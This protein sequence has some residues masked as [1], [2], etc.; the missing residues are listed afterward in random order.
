MAGNSSPHMYTARTRAQHTGFPCSL[1]SGWCVFSQRSWCCCLCLVKT[2]V[3]LPGPLLLAQHHWQ[4]FHIYTRHSPSTL[5]TAHIKSI[6]N[7]STRPKVLPLLFRAY[8]WSSILYHLLLQHKW[9]CLKAECL[10]VAS[11]AFIK[12]E[13]KET[14]FVDV[15]L[16]KNSISCIQEL[17]KIWR[18]A[19]NMPQEVRD[20]VC[21]A[22]HLWKSA[23]SIT[24]RAKSCQASCLFIYFAEPLICTIGQCSWTSTSRLIAK[25][26]NCWRRN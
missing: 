22:S 5:L 4:G 7:V 3:N 16:L 15:K 12:T 6:G 11:Y 25:S 21:K 17:Y 13:W 18:E 1:S 14:N 26:S 10:V 9:V 19:Q 24:D 8:F 20:L 2:L 23:I